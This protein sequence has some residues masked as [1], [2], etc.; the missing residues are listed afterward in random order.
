VTYSGYRTQDEDKSYVYVTHDTGK[1]WEDI[2]GGAQNP[3][4]DIEEDPDNPNI[5]YLATDYG[6]FV[7]F[8]KGKTWTN[9]SSTAP[10]VIIKDLAVQKRDRDLVI[11]TYGRGIYIADIFP[12][13]EFNPDL[14]KKDVH[15]FDV[16]DTIKW[17]RF[18][19]RGQTLGEFAKAANPPVG[20]AIY[21]YLKDK[22]ASVTL[23][24]KD[25]ADGV[26]QEIK[27]KTEKG[28]QKAFWNLDRKVDSE[29]LENLSREE[30]AKLTRLDPGTFS[31]TLSVDGKDV[32][33][34]KAVIKPD[35]VF[36][37]SEDD[38]DDIPE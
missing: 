29:K 17:N 31:V 1:T 33:T 28:F 20:A 32:V 6:L 21:Y 11:A 7:T 35:P 8:D 34:K 2:S 36:Q 23:T 26:V 30:R 3:V 15:L 27:G 5:L 16:E 37:G 24:I 4:N 22:A 13:K 19:R 12:M 14:F 18:D 10:H 25:A 38:Q 9:F